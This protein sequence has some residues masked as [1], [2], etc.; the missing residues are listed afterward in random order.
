MHIIN[1]GD[2][3]CGAYTPNFSGTYSTSMTANTL[4]A[5][6]LSSGAQSVYA[7]AFSASVDPMVTIDSSFSDP[8]TH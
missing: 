6:T 2:T 5:L 3:F 4:Y 1:E 7:S 8:A